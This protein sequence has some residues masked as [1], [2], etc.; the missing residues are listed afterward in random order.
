MEW[1]AIFF[2][3]LLIG[4]AKTGMQG[5]GTMVVPVLALVAGAKPST[6][7]ILPMLCAADLMAVVYYRRMA[8]WRYILKLLPYALVGFGIALFVD[9]FIPPQLFRHLL[10]FCI[11]IGLIILFYFERKKENPASFSAW[12]I[13]PL[14]G[15]LG[16]F[17]TMTGNAA[18]PVM[19][20]YLLA[21]RLPKYAFVGTGA[22][23][24]LIINFLKLPLQTWVWHNITAETLLINLYS[25]PF[26][27]VGAFLGIL[28]TK[29][30]PE[31]SY[32]SVIVGLT[33]VSTLLLF[34]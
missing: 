6:G 11:L 34:M 26:I 2:S 12:W 13:A 25:L 21:M 33:V 22:W 31:K 1:I 24:F 18:G 28:L 32:R 27:V 17:T 10:A 19:S 23:F 5:L 15:L 3:A 9:S 4:V 30:L 14:F 16:G 8:E 20:V 7:L 29:R